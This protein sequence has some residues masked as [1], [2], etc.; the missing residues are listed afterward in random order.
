MIASRGS[1][2][3]LI[4]A[5]TKFSIRNLSDKCTWTKPKLTCKKVAR[6]TLEENLL[7]F[8]CTMGLL[9]AHPLFWFVN[10]LSL[11]VCETVHCWFKLVWI[12]GFFRITWDN[13]FDYFGCVPS[14]WTVRAGFQ[15][16]RGGKAFFIIL[17]HVQSFLLCRGFLN[18]RGLFQMIFGIILVVCKVD[19]QA[20]QVSSLN[21][22]AKLSL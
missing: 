7:D 8:W 4:D 11:T 5:T 12:F 13:F 17:Q 22:D 10:Y 14:W 6:S 19:G 20:G 2:G 9:I 21:E 1:A 15:F 3:G 18:F 16:E